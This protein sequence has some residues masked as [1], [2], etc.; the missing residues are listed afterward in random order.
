MRYFIQLALLLLLIQTTFAENIV[1]DEAE[2]IVSWILNF[3]DDE[4]EYEDRETVQ[5]EWEVTASPEIGYINDH[6]ILS[7]YKNEM[8]V[9]KLV[10]DYRSLY[11]KN[12]SID[13][14]TRTLKV[15]G[16]SVR[17]NIINNIEKAPEPPK[18]VEKE[19]QT[20]I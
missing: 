16:F 3:D 2:K 4:C 7:D 8:G 1:A 9:G 11:Q 5:N 17:N 15:L 10:K 12:I 13:Q 18:P 14:M 6:W 20:K 19:V